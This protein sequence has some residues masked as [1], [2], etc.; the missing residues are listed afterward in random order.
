MLGLSN[1]H[2]YQLLDWFGWI[3]GA[4]LF[5][6]SAFGLAVIL[7]SP[8]PAGLTT[9]SGVLFALVAGGLLFLPDAP[10]VARALFWLAFP[11][12]EPAPSGSLSVATAGILLP[13]AGTS[14]AQIFAQIWYPAE[15]RAEPSVAL[16]AGTPIACPELMAGAPLSS[17]ES[18]FH[19]ILYAPGNGGQ[20]TDSA[21]TAAELASHGYVV[22]AIDDIDH[23]PHP[24]NE[25]DELS[26]PLDLHFPT[27]A[28][29]EKA[30]RTG[31]R[32]AR[33]Q[34][35]RAMLAL[36]VLEACANEDWRARV[37]FDKAGFLGFSFGGA[38]AAEAATFDRRVAAAV[39]L[40]GW[41][42]GRAAFGAINKPYMI[43][44]SEETDFPQE[45]GLTSAKPNRR[46]TAELTV[47]DL[48]EEIRLANR[49]DGFGFRILRSF[50]ENLSDRIFRRTNFVKWLGT[51]PSRVRS[52]RNAYVLA[53]F[54]TYIRQIPSRLLSQ[55]PSPFCGIEVLKGNQTWQGKVAKRAIVSTGNSP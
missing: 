50:H 46:F 53:F 19:V 9:I 31:D 15:N 44:L 27:A 21:P 12:S 38:T 40:D 14:G 24:E 5:A 39:N 28:A 6:M 18:S 52:I 37:R 8:Q 49:P 45:R 10:R 26:Q 2:F 42:F 41:L 3:P 29:F 22:L 1:L 36:D 54:D 51:D 47:R 30:L 32:K 17:K 43:I 55:S 4:I 48:E 7:R 34:A 13:S 25:G 35:E 16:Q 23:E 11:P 20:R 33:R